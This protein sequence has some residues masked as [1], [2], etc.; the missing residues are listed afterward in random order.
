MSINHYKVLAR[1]GLVHLC[2]TNICVWVR[3]IVVETL[4]VINEPV[5]KEVAPSIAEFI[6]NLTSMPSSYNL[7]VHVKEKLDRKSNMI[8]LSDKV[9]YTLLNTY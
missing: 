9:L 1:F 4:T 3:A 7:S 6:S 8:V 5:A 2:V